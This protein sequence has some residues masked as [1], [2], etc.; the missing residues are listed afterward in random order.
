M[1]FVELRDDRLVAGYGDPAD[2]VMTLL[3]VQLPDLR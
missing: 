1:P 3:S 2:P